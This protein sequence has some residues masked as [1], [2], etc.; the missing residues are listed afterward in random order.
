MNAPREKK[1]AR[2]LHNPGAQQSIRLRQKFDSNH[3]L[4]KQLIASGRCMS[5]VFAMAVFDAREEA[6]VRLALDNAA[7][8]GEQD[9][10]ARALIQ[11]LRRRGVS[12]ESVI[13]G[14]EL[15]AKQTALADPGAVLMPWD[16]FRGLPL[17]DIDLKYLRW[18]LWKCPKAKICSV[19]RAVTSG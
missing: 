8:I 7:S 5:G 1:A 19:I 16:K 14:Q 18:V 17:R 11:S 13:I 15:E 10:A 2:T 4:V 12:H 6:P 3:P 9:N